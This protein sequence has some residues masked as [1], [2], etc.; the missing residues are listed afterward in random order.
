MKRKSFAALL[1]IVTIVLAVVAGCGSDNDN[2]IPRDNNATPQDNDVGKTR[3]YLF[4]QNSNSGTF[5]GNGD[6]PLNDTPYFSAILFISLHT[7]S[8]FWMLIHDIFI[9][10]ICIY[11]P[12]QLN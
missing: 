12:I 9:L 2:V 11:S 3:S 8:N 10:A 6:G 7:S 4:V 5:V 1:L